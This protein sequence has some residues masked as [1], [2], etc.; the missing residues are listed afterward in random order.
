MSKLTFRN[1]SYLRNDRQKLFCLYTLS[2]WGL[3]EMRGSLKERKKFQFV[4][5][6]HSRVA[7][8]YLMRAPT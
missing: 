5:K 7:L 2:D 8:I 1:C 3:S 6:D 4:F